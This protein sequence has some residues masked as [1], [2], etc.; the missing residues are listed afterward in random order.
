MIDVMIR[1]D[2]YIY[3]KIIKMLFNFNFIVDIYLI[4]QI[5]NLYYINMY[6]Y[7]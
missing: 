7:L 1:Y 6:N 4:L 2:I 3:I 5:E